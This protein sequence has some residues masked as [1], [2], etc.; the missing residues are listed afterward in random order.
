MMIYDIMETVLAGTLI[1]AGDENGLR[2]LNFIDG[3]RPVAPAPTWRRDP[4]YFSAVRSQL[5]AYFA[6]E[7]R[8]FDVTLC[9]KGTPFQQNVW[10]ELRN[11]PY[12]QVVSY[13][14][15]A[16]RIS[17]PRAARAVGAANS[18]NPISIIIPCHRVIGKDG[19]LTGYGGG[20]EVKKKLL[21]LEK[22]TDA[23]VN[24]ATGP[25]PA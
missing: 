18:R 23:L 22:R 24:A 16:D 12:G 2:H 10:A 4:Q 25:F 17:S 21:R 5:A 20:L 7:C 13:Q 19:R 9:P 11:I 15:V 6:G 1:L 3:K 14:W 8:H